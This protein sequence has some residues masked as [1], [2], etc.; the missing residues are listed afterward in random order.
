MTE[1]LKSKIRTLI[2]EAYKSSEQM[3]ANAQYLQNK[4][5]PGRWEIV[6]WNTPSFDYLNTC[7]YASYFGLILGVERGSGIWSYYLGRMSLI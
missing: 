7:M 4:L 5:G 1:N 3:D 2:E 6:I